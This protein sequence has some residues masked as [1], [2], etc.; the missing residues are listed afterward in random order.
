MDKTKFN[1]NKLKLFEAFAGIGAQRRA[2][3]NIKKDYKVVGMAEWYVPAII[4][5]QAIH[6]NLKIKPIDHKINSEIMISYLESKPLSMDSK[7][8]V[9]KGYWKRLRLNELRIVYK[10]V[11]S[12]EEEGNIFD[13]QNLYKR[14][15]K[16]VDLLTYSFPCQDLSQQGK[17]RGMKSGTRSGLLWEIEKALD[18]TPKNQLPKYLLMENVTALMNKTFEK[19]RNKWIKKLESY[20][21]KNNIGIL[22]AGD[23]G[24]SQARRRVF[25]IS[26]LEKEIK[27]PIKTSEPK[28]IKR[29]LD[30]EPNLK[31][32]MPSLDK[33]DIDPGG[34]KKTKSNIN[35]TK[36][37]DYSSFNSEAYVYDPNFTG[38]TLTASGA[39]SRIKI[40]WKGKIRRINPREA[41]RYMGFNKIDYDKVNSL[42]Y[43]SETK[44]I[45]TCGNSISVEVLEAI[46]KEI[47]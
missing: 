9:T 14:N 7:K 28:P 2:L 44:M 34:Y 11:K 21:Y 15:L 22:N 10:A 37:I 13:V 32:F 3:D 26:S 39:N 18:F 30:K 5:Y 17:Q 43:L 40:N 35:K 12:S 38:P 20:G 23:F 45:Y 8:L 25:M 46:F 41:Y 27:L 33:Y 1:G 19:D 29:I 42:N 36:L 31:Y 4:S 16:D 6:N 24:S 47:R